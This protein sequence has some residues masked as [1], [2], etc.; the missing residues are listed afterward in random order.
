MLVGAFHIDI[1]D[2]GRVIDDTAIAQ[3]KGVCGAGIEP[4]IEHVIDL[5]PTGRIFKEIADLS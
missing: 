4:D 1:C 2:A 5:V 3:R